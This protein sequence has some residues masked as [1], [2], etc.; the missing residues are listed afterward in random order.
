MGMVI[1]MMVE[2]IMIEIIIIQIKPTTIK[3]DHPL[4]NHLNTRITTIILITI[5]IILA[6]TIIQTM[7]TV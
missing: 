2:I 7:P 3:S 5:A 1:E 6:I 4:P